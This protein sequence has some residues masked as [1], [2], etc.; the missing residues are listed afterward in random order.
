VN[1]ITITE[2]QPGKITW[3]GQRVPRKDVEEEI[4]R[5]SNL[6]ETSRRV[7]KSAAEFLTEHQIRMEMDQSKSLTDIQQ[8][9]KLQKDL[10]RHTSNAT[11]AD[12]KV[13][14]LTR[15]NKTKKGEDFVQLP[16]WNGHV[17]EVQI[18][19]L[20]DYVPS[21]DAI[22]YLGSLLRT[23][24]LSNLFV[25]CR[26]GLFRPWTD[27][28]LKDVTTAALKGKAKDA[29]VEFKK[30]CPMELVLDFTKAQVALLEEEYKKDTRRQS[31]NTKSWKPELLAA[32]SLREIAYAYNRQVSGSIKTLE[33]KGLIVVKSNLYAALA[34]LM[35]RN[36]GDDFKVLE[37]RSG[38]P[39]EGPKLGASGPNISYQEQQVAETVIKFMRSDPQF[40]EFMRTK[41]AAP[42]EPV[43]VPS[44]TEKTSRRKKKSASPL[45][46]AAAAL[47]EDDDNEDMGFGD[48]GDDGHQPSSQEEADEKLRAARAALAPELPPK[49]TFFAEMEERFAAQFAR[50]FQLF[51]GS[52]HT[53]DKGM[54]AFLPADSCTTF[55][56]LLILQHIYELA[57]TSPTPPS[58]ANLLEADFLELDMETRRYFVAVLSAESAI[59]QLASDDA[60][61]DYIYRFEAGGGN[62]SPTNQLSKVY[63]LADV[64]YSVGYLG[65][66]D[67]YADGSVAIASEEVWNSLNN[68]AKTTLTD[69]IDHA[70]GNMI[71]TSNSFFTDEQSALTFVEMCKKFEALEDQARNEYYL[72][73]NFPGPPPRTFA[74]SAEQSASDH[75]FLQAEK[76]GHAMCG[77]QA[78]LIT[79]VYCVVGVCPK[80]VAAFEKGQQ[81]EDDGDISYVGT[82][83]LIS[84]Q[85]D[86]S[87]YNEGEYHLPSQERGPPPPIPPRGPAPHL[88]VTSSVL[89]YCVNQYEKHHTRAVF[90]DNGR[91]WLALELLASGA[92]LLSEYTLRYFPGMGVYAS[93]VSE[94]TSQKETSEKPQ[95]SK[96]EKEK[97][98][99]GKAVPKPDE[100]EVEE[101]QTEG[102]KNDKAPPKVNKVSKPKA[103]GATSTDEKSSEKKSTDPLDKS[104]P[105]RVKG[106]PRSNDLTDEQRKRLRAYFKLDE[107]RVDPATWKTLAAKKDAASKKQMSKMRME[108]SIPKWAVAA[109][110]R[111][112]ANLKKIEDGLLTKEKS[113]SSPQTK[114]TGTD[115]ASEWKKVKDR[116]KTVGLYSNPQTGPEKALR[117]AFDSLKERFP[118]N[119]S[120]PK[121]R[122]KPGGGDKKNSKKSDSEPKSSSSSSNKRDKDNDDFDKL[123]KL[124]M[125]RMM[126]D[127]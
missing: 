69:V 14:D 87:G 17:D 67:R 127:M 104:R 41:T 98:K 55:R 5:Q 76:I 92:L 86:A 107:K 105:I 57:W 117:K 27:E 73:E 56:K 101:I 39:G 91:R 2:A 99:K 10:D 125:A 111:D 30:Q 12:Q 50:T 61:R 46:K 28:A 37:R 68:F 47:G 121:L 53:S 123:I 13:A 112:P 102:V 18:W 62:P 88:D 42:T 75:L 36:M 22:G 23:R 115:C 32:W 97:K 58:L 89:D 15:L 72:N 59:R 84:P 100:S 16:V 7:A 90:E 65:W 34:L 114:A 25:D 94:A 21:T 79:K 103:K 82:S 9:E 29:V 124:M 108:Q 122:Q 63:D 26:P 35:P 45:S 11:Q 77:I 64:I 106:V 51:D 4:R 54:P 85:T 119:P 8:L 109:V 81:E 43:P 20:S 31:R 78:D 113:S 40:A 48:E 6:A 44:R 49:P 96:P 93:A 116:F 110:R 80:W 38:R 3:T 24:T 60:R 74:A 118:G 33:K 70:Y 52:T 19:F 83:G 120:L 66:T 126:K 95:P 1:K 71:A